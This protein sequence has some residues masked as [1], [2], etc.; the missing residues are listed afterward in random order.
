[1]FHSSRV[2]QSQPLNLPPFLESTLPL[3]AFKD[4]IFISYLFSKLFEGSNGGENRCGLPMDWIP[5][6][7][8]TPQ[9]SRHKSWDAL[10][11][12]VFGQAH[13]SY[14]VI[15]N[16]FVLYGQALSELRDKLS[17]PDDRRTD[18]VLASMTALYVYEVSYKV[19]ILQKSTDYCRY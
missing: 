12:I 11:A 2:R 5:E 19:I 3:T 16:A 14:N 17:N 8:K 15:T 13:K 4:D 6:L 7:V 9:K 18:S 1:V 10:A